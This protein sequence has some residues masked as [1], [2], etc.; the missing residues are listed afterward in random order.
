MDTNL[1]SSMDSAHKYAYRYLIYQGT[2]S[3]RPVAYVG[4]AW[5]ERW[6]LLYWFRERRR[7]RSVG[8]LANWLHNLA[9][10]S[11]IDFVGFD[12]DTFWSEL[13]ELKIA[14]PADSFGRFRDYFKFAVSEFNEGR[15]PALEV[16]KSEPWAT[17]ISNW[18]RSDLPIRPGATLES[19]KEFEEKYQVTLPAD[20]AEYLQTVDGT[21][22]DESDENVLSFLP[23]SE[24]RPVH[25][26]LDDS[27]GVVYSDRFAY[28]DCFVFAD[29]LISS[30]LYAVQITSDP[31]N[32]GP[33]YRVTGSDAP[34]HMEAASFREFMTRYA[35]D[36]GS[37]I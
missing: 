21:G 37:V 27:G 31:D 6:N 20:F 8:R 30:W 23:L 18:R 4:S 1:H 25:E 15:K 7:I 9:L 16:R 28:P 34:V 32:S 35:A 19:I 2:L 14:F 33:V 12:E 26:V 10:F 22:V 11:A 36:P 3:I 13:E 5:W 29:Y 17:I 24:I